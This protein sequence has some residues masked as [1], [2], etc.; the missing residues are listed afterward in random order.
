M[1]LKANSDKK[2]DSK[3]RVIGKHILSGL[4]AC[5]MAAAYGYFTYPSIYAL[6]EEGR[7]LEANVTNL[8]YIVMLLLFDKML[9]RFTNQFLALRKLLSKNLFTKMV[10]AMLLPK[11]GLISIKSGLYVFYIF[12]LVQSKAMQVS[13]TLVFSSSFEQYII[14]MEYG[15]VMLLAADT[16]IKQLAT[17]QGRIREIEIIESSDN[18]KSNEQHEDAK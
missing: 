3:I 2:K 8:S 10:R 13:P 12:V 11:I 18:S 5:I 9:Y 15:L 16:L 17:D 7:I 14:T 6:I 1:K 4:A